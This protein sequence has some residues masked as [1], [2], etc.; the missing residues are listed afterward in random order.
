MYI[1]L[2]I[3]NNNLLSIGILI[4][5]QNNFIDYFVQLGSLRRKK[6]GKYFPAYIKIVFYLIL[7]D[8]KYITEYYLKI[9]MF[10]V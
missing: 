3:L 1:I 5:R 9:L 2:Y 4:Q 6:L 10:F 8:K 7:L